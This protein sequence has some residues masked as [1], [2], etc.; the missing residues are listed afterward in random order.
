[1]GKETLLPPSSGLQQLARWL[2][3]V[4]QEEVVN[5]NTA[6]GCWAECTGEKGRRQEMALT[7][8]PEEAKIAA[9]LKLT[10]KLLIQ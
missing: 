10:T 6:L 9:Y 3:Q 5:R 1:M 8:D 2:E 7:M 4:L